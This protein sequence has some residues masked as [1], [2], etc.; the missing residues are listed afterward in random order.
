MFFNYFCWGFL[1]F[2]CA[3]CSPSDKS[4]QN[5]SLLPS[6]PKVSFRVEKKN[7]EK[8]GWKSEAFQEKAK[9]QLEKLSE[10]LTSTTKI[11]PQQIS[12]IVHPKILSSILRPKNLKQVWSKANLKVW[13]NLEK[14]KP[15]HQKTQNKFCKLLENLIYP[16]VSRGTSPKIHWKIVGV[17]PSFEEIKIRV[18]YQA[19]SHKSG[20]QIEQNATWLCSWSKTTPPLLQSV[21]VEDYEE[22]VLSS[23]TLFSDCTKSVL[24]KNSCFEKQLMRGQE[25]WM[26]RR[27][28]LI[29]VDN[30]G[31]HGVAIGDVNGDGRDDLY[32]CQ[33]GGLPNRLFIQNSDGT[34]TDISENSGTNFRERTHSA[35]FLDLDNDHDQDLVLATNAAIIVM[36]NDG[37]GKF[38]L[39]TEGSFPNIYSLAAADYDQ[40]GDLDIYATSYARQDLLDK[41]AGLTLEPIPYHDANNGAPNALFENQGK[42]QFVDV[43]NKVGL[44][45]NNKRWSFAASWEDFDN[46]GDMDLYVANDF[47]RNN[48]YRNEKGF[49]TDVAQKWGVEDIASGMGV[50]FGD[51]D[52]DGYM[53]LY[54][55]NMF[56]AAG[57]RIAFQDQF[58]SQAN[59]LTRQHF[60]RLARGNTL[61]RNTGTSFE[62]LSESSRVS[63]GRWSWG[64]LFVDINNDG[65]QDI[66]APNGYITNTKTDDL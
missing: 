65:W 14:N 5:S 18:L 44:E 21:L 32:L 35:L 12:S 13:R 53:D 29:G 1:L 63:M 2:L 48:L 28:F 46:D 54:V 50:S 58:Q 36:S 23:E 40:D 56:S 42:F 49:F 62:D 64:S 8:E 10:L 33:T 55:S 24:G 17:D 34:A 19:S 15:F 20:E 43:T 11:T 37:Q 41:H 7:P 6:L 9:K 22:V 59:S 27:P 30:F 57:K 25:H 66:I 31:H 47:G 61:F 4:P 51:Y 60:Q 52:R 39:V 26:R 16:F 38:R 3:G 45:S